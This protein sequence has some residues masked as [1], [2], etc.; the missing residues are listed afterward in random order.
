MKTRFLL[1]LSVLVSLALATAVWRIATVSSVPV[2]SPWQE[3]VAQSAAPQSF[4]PHRANAQQDIAIARMLWRGLYQLETT[5]DGGAQAVPAMA[6]GPPS[7]NGNVYTVGLKPGLMW[8]DDEPLTAM[9]F[10]YGIKRACDPDVGDPYQYLLGES[11]LNIVGCDAYFSGQGTRDDVGVTA[12]NATT[13]EITLVAPKPAF[14]TI[15]S[16]WVGFPV[17]QDVIETYGEGW[18]D[19]AHIVVNGPFTLTELVPGT[20]GHAVLEPNPNWALQPEPILREITIRFIDDL[21][22]AFQDFQ[23]GELDMTMVPAAEI[24]TIEADPDLD[25]LFLKVGASRIWAVEMQLNDPT[26]ANFNVRLALSRA[27]DRNALVNAVYDGA[28]LP[29]TYWLVQGLSGFQGNAA[30]EN[31]IGYNSTAA[32]AALTAAGYPNGQGFP[33]LTLTVLNRPDRLAEG[34]FLQS[35]WSNILG[36]N[37]VIQAVDAVTRSQIFNSENFDLFMGGWQNDYPDPENSLIGLFDTGGGN[38]KYNCSDPDI[39]AKLSAAAAETNNATRIGLL[40]DAETLI[41]TRLCGV[42][43][44]HET[45]SLYLVKSKIAGV[46]PNGQIDAGMPGNW[47]PECWFV[48]EEDQDSDGFW[49]RVEVYVGTDPLDAC[50]DDTSDDA[51]PL[52]V[53][54]DGQVSVVGDVLN[55]RGRIGAT[56]GSPQWWQ[57][58]DFNA[59]GQLSVVGDVLLYRGLIGETCT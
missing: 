44:V 56:P 9:D 16:L 15:M 37:V 49:D 33:T 17:R 42:A 50:P 13:L 8:S 11:G 36:V 14:T 32:R 26:I 52:D 10:E 35:A 46:E 55:F 51:W 47:C 28:Y 25:H 34:M 57:R 24:P 29:A 12:A 4:D 45:A 1:S 40:Q 41:V 22:A 58:L 59:D 53:N 21:E 30:F 54:K 6:A 5:P 2:P 31:I 23:A 48:Q 27:I 19:P 20:G 3:I 43:P 18:T 7:V 38:N 39:D